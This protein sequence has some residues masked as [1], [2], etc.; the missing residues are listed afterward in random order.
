MAT[1]DAA[2]PSSADVT[3]TE[4]DR[5]AEQ[6]PQEQPTPLPVKRARQRDAIFDALVALM[7]YEPQSKSERSGWGGCVKELKELA[8]TPDEIALRGRR[9]GK[10]YGAERL[11]VY[12]L[13]KHWGE[14]SQEPVLATL[15]ATGTSDAAP[16]V[17]H[18]VDELSPWK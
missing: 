13:V 14:F 12:A 3:S 8:A 18:T 1:A 6:P 15:K 17:V 16:R 4:D 10:K 11:T 7:G 5:P 9:Y 2:P